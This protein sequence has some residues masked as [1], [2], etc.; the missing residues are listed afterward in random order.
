MVIHRLHLI[1]HDG[2]AFETTHLPFLQDEEDSDS[3][4]GQDDHHDHGCLF[5]VGLCIGYIIP[6]WGHLSLANVGRSWAAGAFALWYCY[7]ILSGALLIF[8]NT[9]AALLR[10][11]IQW[12]SG[13]SIHLDVFKYCALAR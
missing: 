4:N 12:F 13:I 10:C 7:I 3:E 2:V 6:T 5:R 9:A 1:Q 8:F 11:Y